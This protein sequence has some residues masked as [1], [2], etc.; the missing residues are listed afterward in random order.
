MSQEDT[1]K[2]KDALL[3]IMRITAD[4]NEIAVFLRPHLDRINNSHL[5]HFHNCLQYKKLAFYVFSTGI[6]RIA[7]DCMTDSALRELME[8]VI[9]VFS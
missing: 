3:F 5:T 4:T 1:Q 8:E 9:R 2:I 7:M 6:H